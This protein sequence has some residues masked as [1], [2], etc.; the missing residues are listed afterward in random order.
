MV[1][2]TDFD[3]DVGGVQRD[4]TSG[5]KGLAGPFSNPSKYSEIGKAAKGT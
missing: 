5:T 4:F 3:V 1:D 2:H